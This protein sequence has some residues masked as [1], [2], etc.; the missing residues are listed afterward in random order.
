MIEIID[1]SKSFVLPDASSLEIFD[2]MSLRIKSGDFVSIMGP[3]GQGKTT[4]LNILAGIE[5][6]YR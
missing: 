5:R 2:D 3:S 1:L 6:Q 4:L